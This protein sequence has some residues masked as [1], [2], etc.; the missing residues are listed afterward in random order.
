MD[1]FNLINGCFM[2]LQKIDLSVKTVNGVCSGIS[3]YKHHLCDELCIAKFGTHYNVTH[4]DSGVSLSGRS[5][6]IDRALV[7]LLRWHHISITYGVSLENGE[8]IL[9]EFLKI[10]DAM[11]LF[12]LDSQ[13]SVR[14]WVT[15]IYEGVYFDDFSHKSNIEDL[16]KDILMITSVY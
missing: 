3:G 11:V 1:K 2:K 4:I 16:E 8:C 5:N 13:I 14:E 7:T 15:G 10:N 9:Q 12:N 6:H